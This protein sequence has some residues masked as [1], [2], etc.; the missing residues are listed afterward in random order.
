MIDSFI[1]GLPTKLYFGKKQEEKVGK[2]LKEYG[3]KRVLLIYGQNSIIRSGLLNKV[4][5]YIEQES[6]I[7]I[8]L[9]GVRPNPTIELVREGIQLARLERIDFILALGGGSVMDVAKLISTGFYYDGDPFDISHKLYI[10]TK[11]LPL[12]VI[13]TIAASGSEMST[14]CVVQEDAT[15]IKRGYNSEFNRPLFA[16]ENPELTFSVSKIQT[17]YGIVDILMH[18]LERYFS[19][20]SSEN[21]PADDFSEALLKATLKSG[22]IAYNEPDNYDARA[23][24]LFLSS[25]SHNG[26]TSIGKKYVMPVHQLE[27]VLS[28]LYPFVAHGAGL[29]ALFP[30][31]AEYYL[32]Y[33]LDKFNRFAQ[34]VFNLNYEDKKINAKKGLE[35]LVDYFK[36]L[37]M[38]LSFKELG[39]E[40]PNI[41]KM[42]ELF[43]ED[44]TRVIAHHAKSL[45][46]EVARQIY[47]ALRQ[48]KEK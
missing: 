2:I 47:C 24:L 18:T 36:K 22:L 31:W 25:F 44:G 26:L 17:G 46:G 11:A 10:P 8:E 6:I 37:N 7:I 34:N 9:P 48:E 15:G 14:S 16:I 41:D 13:V 19:Y 28:G 39:I 45:D 1:F 43:T 29:A 12:G 35:Q 33:D 23:N 27:H 21:E 3:A 20:S 32:E 40:E 38:P 42:V 5:T 30:C 4:K